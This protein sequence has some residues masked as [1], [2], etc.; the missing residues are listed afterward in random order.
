MQVTAQVANDG[1][2]SV[3]D[4]VGIVE[5]LGESVPT[6]LSFF[7]EDGREVRLA[8]YFDGEK[9]VILNFVYHNCPMLCSILLES[10]TK[11]LKDLDWTPGGE[12]DV[13]TISFSAIETPE[14]AS[15]Q[16]TRY[17]KTLDRP[18]AASGWHFLTG[19]EENI[20]ALADATGFSF[21]WIESS[22]EFAHPAA[23]IFLD[24]KANITR[25]IHGMNF[26][27]LDLRK[28]IVEASEGRV[29][30]SVDRILLYCYRYDAGA[31]SYVLDAIKLMKIGGLMTLLVVGL[32][33]L[34]FWRRERQ[35]LTK[36]R[37]TQESIA[38]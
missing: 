15:A 18:E 8:E 5:K 7:N 1:L 10:F 12:F 22:K 38:L 32:G 31:N 11:S 33:L 19:S 13:L 17:L 21:K 37:P 30:T 16:K 9:P 24:G 3:F 35:Q 4:G 28:A 27:P 25:Y 6:E 2:P 23:L 29:G 36:K 34:I 14:L 20:F 26:P